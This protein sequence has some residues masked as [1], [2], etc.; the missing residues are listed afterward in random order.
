MNIEF[1]PHCDD[2]SDEL[3]NTC[4]DALNTGLINTYEYNEYICPCD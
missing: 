4:C 3:L 2:G 1:G